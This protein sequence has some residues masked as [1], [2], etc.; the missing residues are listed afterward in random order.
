MSAA[1]NGPGAPKASRHSARCIRRN[2]GYRFSPVPIHT[3]KGASNPRCG[4]LGR[5]ALLR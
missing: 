1:E 5:S 3:S 2:S 4:T